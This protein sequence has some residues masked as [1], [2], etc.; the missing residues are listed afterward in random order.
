MVVV[1]V[2]VFQIRQHLEDRV[3]DPLDKV[4]RQ[5]QG[6]QGVHVHEPISRHKR[7]FIA[8]EKQPLQFREAYECLSIARL[9]ARFVQI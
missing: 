6:L 1:E 3:V 4:K 8:P 7:Q 5:V 2:E 9:Y